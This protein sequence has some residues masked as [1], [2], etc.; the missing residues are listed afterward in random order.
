[1]FGQD[2]LTFYERV[3]WVEKHD[4]DIVRC[5][6]NPLDQRWWTEADEP[7]QF[8]ATCRE[9]AEAHR[10]GFESHLPIPMD[11][12][13]NG[14][15]HLSLM[16]R[17][18]VGARAT[19]C[20]D[21]EERSDLYE[22][23]AAE[24]RRLVQTDLARGSVEASNWMAEGIDRKVVKR[25]VM[26]TPYGVTDRGIRDQL[27]SDGHTEGLEGTPT[28]NA[29]YM[30]EKISEALANTVTAAREIMSYIQTVASE[31]AQADIPLTWRAPSGLVVTQAYYNLVE[32]RVKTLLGKFQFWDEDREMGLNV[33]KQMLAASPNVVHSFDAAMLAE[34]AL[35]AER[36]GIH[37]L[38]FVHDSYGTHAA[39]THE[40]GAVLRHVAA[41]MYQPDR[42]AEFHEYVQGYAPDVKLPPRPALGTFDVD[43]VR[44]ARYFFA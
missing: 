10:S 12:T 4:Q 36:R 19:N 3:K 34:T 32:S 15:Q 42:L 30:Q 28:E 1:M 31:L 24:V 7:W 35:V 27:I 29:R 6:E 20:A 38:A 37:A 18:A 43:E 26:T 40:L 2:K 9:W 33:R 21:V 44:R 14:L 8:L 16:G 5:A 22:E 13:C 11:G 39:D 25:A 41:E 17:D 23:V